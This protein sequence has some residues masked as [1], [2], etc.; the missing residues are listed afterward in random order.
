M[1]E[2]KYRLYTPG[3]IE[4]YHNSGSPASGIIINNVQ[5]NANTCMPPQG[6]GDQA[7]N[8]D[9]I[10]ASGFSLRVLFGQKRDRPNVTWRCAVVSVPKGTALTYATLLEAQTANCLLD[11]WNT[12]LCTV[13]WQKYY[14]PAI[15]MD[16]YNTTAGG[17][18]TASLEYT[19]VRKFWIKRKM[20]YKFQTDGSL[21]HNDRDVHFV[22][23]A[24]DA[25]GSLI[26]DN[27]GYFQM[28]Q[29]FCYRDP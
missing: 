15:P 16:S 17:N 10:Y 22:V 3:K 19:F 9:R 12:D 8:G 1:T 20:E 2:P 24:Y 28:W 6:N 23:F 29:K 5:M 13:L 14:K 18:V 27:I 21:T 26:T 7:R 25:Y 11:G 4:V